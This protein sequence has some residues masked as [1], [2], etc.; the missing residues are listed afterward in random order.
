M[1]KSLIRFLFIVV[2]FGCT[3]EQQTPRSSYTHVPEKPVTFS[4]VC[5]IDRGELEGES[6]QTLF[7]L[8]GDNKVVIDNLPICQPIAPRE[9][10]E[11]GIPQTAI[12]AIGGK[13]ASGAAYFYIEKTANKATVYKLSADELDGETG[14]AEVVYEVTIAES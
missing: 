14:A 8:Y 6:V 5:E 11:I 1:K 7:L 10:E 13:W 9:W 12:D 2:L 4:F 3:N